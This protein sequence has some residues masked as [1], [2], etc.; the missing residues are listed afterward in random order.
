MLGSVVS[1]CTSNFTNEQQAKE[2][3]EFF[4][5]KDTKGFDRA[6]A[7]SLDSIAAKASWISRDK[8][9]VE[10][11]LKKNKYLENEESKL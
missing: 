11:W 6:L 1:M 10:E 5:D 3:A 7:Q 2:V 9:D 4:K 8:T